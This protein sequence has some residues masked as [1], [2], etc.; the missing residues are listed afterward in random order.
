MNLCALCVL[1]MVS[2]F[3]TQM[4]FMFFATIAFGTIMNICLF[5]MGFLE[6]ENTVHQMSS[7]FLD[8][9]VAVLAVH[10]VYDEK[11]KKTLCFFK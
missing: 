3:C 10:S 6:Q 11:C 4:V 1:I 5:I 8:S 7:C 9:G 2:F